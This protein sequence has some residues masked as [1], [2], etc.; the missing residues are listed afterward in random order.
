M[1]DRMQ[2]WIEADACDG[3]TLQPGFMP[4]ELDLFCT[5]VAPLLQARDL[6]R[7]EYTGTTLSDHLGL[8]A[9]A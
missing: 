4:L 5:E 2:T 3:F 8:R 6:L 7:R 9:S 1:A